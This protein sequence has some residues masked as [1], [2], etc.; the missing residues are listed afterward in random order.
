MRYSPVSITINDK[1]LQLLQLRKKKQKLYVQAYSS[2]GLEDN[3]SW[4]SSAV[5]SYIKKRLRRKNFKGNKCFAMIGGDETTY[6]NIKTP[7][8]NY[9]KLKKLMRYEVE[10]HITT[11]IQATVCD[12]I[13]LRNISKTEMEVLVI[14]INREIVKNCM[15][16][17]LDA[18]LCPVAIDAESLTLLRFWQF[19]VSDTRPSIVLHS[20]DNSSRL[21]LTKDAEYLFSRNIPV[22]YSAE[23][24]DQLISEINHSLEYY[25]S[26]RG[27]N[28]N[29]NSLY[30]VG[31]KTNPISK[32][33]TAALGLPTHIVTVTDSIDRTDDH[34][35]NSC[36]KF[37]LTI[38]LALRAWAR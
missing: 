23:T 4:G 6:R 34:F 1:E 20:G 31:S 7:R 11:D 12:Y 9:K 26:E 25:Q 24:L 32:Q 10:K 38:G 14:A 13:P 16:T 36:D 3:E 33:L 30:L 37:N 27:E 17:M 35:F 29:I 19:S 8:V 5:V 2:T 28:V 18:G 15:T 22:G 21:I